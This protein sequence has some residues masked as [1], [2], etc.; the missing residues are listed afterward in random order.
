[1]AGEG[2]EGWANWETWNVYLWLSNDE[3]A[4][5]MMMDFTQANRGRVTGDGAQEFVREMMPDGTPDFDDA[6]EYDAVD[7]SEIA[8]NMNE[9]W[10][11]D[12]D[13]D[14]DDNDDDD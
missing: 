12:D 4:Y 10:W 2:Y 9:D 14:D 11:E 3:G 7:W 6:E 1:M 5:R 13:G 8:D